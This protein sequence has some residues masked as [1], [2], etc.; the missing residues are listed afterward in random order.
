MKGFNQ[1]ASTRIGSGRSGLTK[2]LHLA[3]TAARRQPMA[4]HG[5]A[6]R[7]GILTK[8]L[9]YRGPGRQ[10]LQKNK[11]KHL[12]E[13]AR[14]CKNRK[15]RTTGTLRKPL[16]TAQFQQ[17]SL[18]L[19]NGLSRERCGRRKSGSGPCCIAAALGAHCSCGGVAESLPVTSCRPAVGHNYHNRSSR[20]RKRDTTDMKQ[21]KI[22][23]KR[24]WKGFESNMKQK[25][26]SNQSE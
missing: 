20:L 10:N 1:A 4:R 24:K 22:D 13:T 9:H 6:M 21:N 5:C 7:A 16:M 8:A 26:S 17:Q 15:Q 11:K 3:Y 23:M 25:G 14:P 2:A 18:L 12:R 19:S